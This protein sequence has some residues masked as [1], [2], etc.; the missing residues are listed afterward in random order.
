M[1]RYAHIVSFDEFAAIRKVM[2]D[3]MGRIV[4]TSGGFDPVH[5]GHMSCVIESRRFGDTLVVVVNGDAFLQAKKGRSFQDT[6]TRCRIMACIREVDYVI[7]FE[8]ENDATVREALRRLRPHV[9][10]KGGDR[11]DQTTIPEWDVCSE[12][13][14]EVESGVGFD[15]QWSSSDFLAEWGR[16]WLERHVGRNE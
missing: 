1:A 13:G 10:T 12:L 15:K 8:I 6:A 11:V 7:P 3:K 5:P 4:C 14:I 9:F 16:F 2:G